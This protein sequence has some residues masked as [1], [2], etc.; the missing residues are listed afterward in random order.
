MQG[1][2]ASL[3]NTS[4]LQL[5]ALSYATKRTA[6]ATCTSAALSPHSACSS[7]A[8]YVTCC[9]GGTH[10]KLL[11]TACTTTGV[12]PRPPRDGKILTASARSPLASPSKYPYGCNQKASLRAR[13]C[14]SVPERILTQPAQQYWVG[15]YRLTFPSVHMNASDIFMTSPSPHGD[16]LMGSAFHQAT[17]G[18]PSAGF[19][20]PLNPGMRAQRAAPGPPESWHASPAGGTCARAW[21]ARARSPRWAGPTRP[22]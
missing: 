10:W 15:P 13:T 11:G 22:A 19:Q 18:S 16:S 14:M 17:E 6:C 1:G 12:A 2:A 9:S 20:G 4:S 5:T 21:R 7:A 8:E 3:R